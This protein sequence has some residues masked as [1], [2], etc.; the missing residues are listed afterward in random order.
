MATTIGTTP[1]AP[2]VVVIGAGF[3]GLHAV[4]RLRAEGLTVTAFEAGDDVGGVWYRNRYPGAQTDTPQEAYQYTFDPELLVDWEY[5]RRLPPQKEVHAYLR[6]VADRYELH[7]HFSFGTTVKTAVFDETTDRWR[8]TTSDGRVVNP[9]FLVT[10][11][12]AVSE[13][14]RPDIEGVDSFAGEVLFTNRWPDTDVELVGKRIALIGTGSSGVQ[15]TPHL[16]KAAAHLTVFQRTPNYVLPSGNR[17]VNEADRIELRENYADVRRRVRGHHA[18]FP[19][20]HAVGRLAVKTPDE[21]RERIFEEAWQRGGFSFFYEAFDD[22]DADDEANALAAE[23]IRSKIR[24]IVNDAATAETLSPYYHY[25]VKRP[26]TGDGY[27]ESFNEPHVDLINLRATPIERITAD[28][29]IVDGRDIP[30]DIIVFATG[31]DIG[32]GSYNRI[33]IQ[34]RDGERL[35]D[36]WSEGPSTYI[37]VAVSGFPNMFMIAGPHSPFANIPPGAENV[38][39]WIAG[40]I[41]HMRSRGANVAEAVAAAEKAWG[42][43]VIESAGDGFIEQAAQSNSWLVGAN[44]ENRRHAITVYLGGHDLYADRLDVEAEGGYPGFSLT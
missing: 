12:G 43:H 3:S 2:D 34:G 44:I 25:G 21:E 28:S 35:S 41:A 26:P 22:I 42:E 5:S 27:Y 7:K 32:V 1:D 18:G 15:I 38:G 13:P 16:A 39:N 29:I 23:F 11:L 31:F 17:D 20:E 30:I 9:R 14:V 4:W 6:Y 37:G 8:I 19:F 40:L 36:H 10:A 24:T 33:D